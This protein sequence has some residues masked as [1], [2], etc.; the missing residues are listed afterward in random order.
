MLPEYL[1]FMALKVGLKDTSSAPPRLAPSALIPEMWECHVLDTAAYSRFCSTVL[2]HEA[3]ASAAPTE[4]ALIHHRSMYDSEGLQ[5]ARRQATGEAY[6][7]CFAGRTLPAAICGGD[8]A[9]ATDIVSA[10]QSVAPVPPPADSMI[11]Q[12]QQPS[13]AATQQ[14]QHQQRLEQHQQHG[15]SSSK[16]AGRHS[17]DDGDAE[18]ATCGGK[19]SSERRG[20][21]AKSAKPVKRGVRGEEAIGGCSDSDW[22]GNCSDSGGDDCGDDSDSDVERMF[23]EAPLTGL[24]DPAMPLTGLLRGPAAA[25]GTPREADSTGDASGDG[26]TEGATARPVNAGFVEW[27]EAVL[28]D[29]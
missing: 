20:V 13:V 23:A 18:G 25:A 17:G 4:D 8:T 7:A 26:A 3:A 1:R 29:I 10:Q 24:L 14:Q 28:G 22:G 6:S 27:Y 11:Q 12:Q 5:A 15:G 21:C 9:V 16:K 2:A 19:R